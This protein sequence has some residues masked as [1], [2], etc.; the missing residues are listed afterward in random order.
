MK[1]DLLGFL[2]M[3]SEDRMVGKMACDLWGTKGRKGWQNMQ[4]THC[5]TD[6]WD[7]GGTAFGLLC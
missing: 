7:A 6:D 2:V 1:T 3:F 4:L 5:I